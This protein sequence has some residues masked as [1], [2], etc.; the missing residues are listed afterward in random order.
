MTKGHTVHLHFLILCYLLL[1]GLPKLVHGNSKSTLNIAVAS[2][3][4]SPMKK[5]IDLFAIETPT[6]IK[7]SVGSSGSLHAQ[8][9]NGAPFELFF[10]A[11]QEKPSSLVAANL[12]S[13][14]HQHTYAIGRLVLWSSKNNIDPHELLLA[15]SFTKLALANPEVAPY[16][17]AA[18]SVLRSLRLYEKYRGRQVQGQN[19]AQTYLYTSSGNAQLGFIS[20]SQNEKP[21]GSTWNIPSSLYQPIKQ[22]VVLINKADNSKI[23]IQFLEFIKSNEAKAIIM[24]YGYGIASGT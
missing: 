5:L 6:P 18:V 4:V 1:G 16:G 22:D 9:V 21:R 24:H 13:K 7:L 23:A 17:E 15:G 2:N 8:I 12:A 14:K 10:S 3:F 11:D 20:A 19:I